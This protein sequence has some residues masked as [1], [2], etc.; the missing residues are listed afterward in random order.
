MLEAKDVFGIYHVSIVQRP[1]IPC[2]VSFSQIQNL[3]AA[4]VREN[5]ETMEGCIPVK[6]I[7]AFHR[8]KDPLIFLLKTLNCLIRSKLG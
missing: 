7:V 4:Q 2:P 6:S 1:C 8:I 3:R 5:S